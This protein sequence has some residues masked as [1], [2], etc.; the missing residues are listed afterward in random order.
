MKNNKEKLLFLIPR[1]DKE[2][3]S[4]SISNIYY[5]SVLKYIKEIYQPKDNKIKNYFHNL[6]NGEKPK[7]LNQN[8]KMNILQAVKKTILS[9]N[10]S[11]K[12]RLISFKRALINMHIRTFLYRIFT[13]F[14]LQNIIDL[15]SYILTYFIK[16]YTSSNLNNTII[17]N[18]N[19]SFNNSTILNITN[20]IEEKTDKYNMYFNLLISN[21]Y[22]IPFWCLL[23]LRYIPKRN[24]IDN[25]ICKITNYLLYIESLENNNYF[26]YL[27]KDYSIFVTKKEYMFKMIEV[28]NT[29]KNF[30][31]I[32]SEKNIFLYCVN[33]I[34][35]Y[36]LKDNNKISYFQLLSN[37]DKTYINELLK[38]ISNNSK[39]YTQNYLKDVIKPFVFAL[40]IFVYNYYGIQNEINII[41]IVCLLLVIL[42]GIYFFKEYLRAHNRNIDL[43]ID[44]YNDVLIPKKRF[45]YR[46]GDL[47]M[48]FALKDNIYSK[49]KIISMI[50]NIIKD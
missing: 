39:E 26:Y 18:T 50:E 29:H 11:Y 24:K 28:L 22:I 44:N 2:E 1:L 36:L 31:N 33:I 27:M 12:W 8:K 46:K 15:D 49:K 9:T 45:I 25:I 32:D 16:S 40:L 37:E 35:D 13:Y 19:E 47:I 20:L 34:D 30:K 3:K 6:I 17:N 21:L 4:S 48:F 23:L 10:L 5:L 14:I 38:Y 43:F 42:F 41:G 7:N